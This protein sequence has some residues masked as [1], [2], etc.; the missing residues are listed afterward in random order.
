MYNDEKKKK[1]QELNE[2]IENSGVVYS[3]ITIDETTYEMTKF[4]GKQGHGFAA[5]RAEH[6][7]DL[8]H[9]K[10]AQ[11]L[12]DDNAKNGADRLVNGTQIQSKYC[13]SGSACIQECFENG[14]YRYYSLNGEPMQIE[15]PRD[16]YDDA[17]KAM[18]RRIEKNEINGVTNPDDA[19]KLVKKG[20]YTYDQAKRI[21]QSGTI[22]SLSFDAA[23]GMIVGADAMGITAVI[24]FATSVWNGDTYEVALENAV[25]SGFKVGGVAFLTTVISS[26][27]ARTTISSSVRLGT[28]W[29]VAKLGPKATAYIA[30]SLRTGTNIYGAAAMNNVSKLMA[31]N[32]VANIASFI[33]LSASDIVNLFRGRISTGQAVKDMTVVG[34][35]LAAGNAGW[36]AGTAIGTAV[37]AT[38][39]GVATAGAG[40][41]A[42]AAI[43]A[44][45]GGFIGSIL[46]G[47]VAGSATKGAMNCIIE[48]DAISMMHIVESEF[49]KI[50]EEYL[51]TEN[52]VYSIL[53][54]L[55]ERLTASELKDMFASSDKNNYARSLI[56]DSVSAIINSRQ[57]IK[58]PSEEEIII[59]ARYLIEDAIDGVGV[60]AENEELSLSMVKENLLVDR[61]VNDEQLPQI[62]HSVMRMN[63]TQKR[64]ERTLIGMKRS[65]DFAN[66][67]LENISAERLFLK[68]ELNKLL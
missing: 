21:A 44:K 53:P 66:E 10:K 39:A 37:G 27:I 34:A 36:A 51:L 46:A 14:K 17:I 4:H 19:E 40:T 42:G 32:I 38:V 26:Q 29:I 8:Y 63:D 56:L 24:T 68:D 12:G 5:E 49:I 43:G 54:K 23:N 55:K 57:F 6:M 59:G 18:K 64:M 3:N 60:F 45:I 7:H 61:K 62:M 15:V 1:K 33:V 35:T 30:N 22:E 11:I 13:K 48:D 28:D 65:N 16:M 41:G 25:L 20:H 31:G 52:E 9:G 50:N 47:T 67:Q 2:E 58:C